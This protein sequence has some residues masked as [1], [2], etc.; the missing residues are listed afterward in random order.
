MFKPEDLTWL[1][2]VSTIMANAEGKKALEVTVLVTD[3]AGDQYEIIASL[4]NHWTNESFW[5][6]FVQG[7][8]AIQV[9]P[10]KVHVQRAIL[11]EVN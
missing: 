8:L 3:K 9:V 10:V 2:G 11:K 6:T 1:P 4:P 7:C 5:K